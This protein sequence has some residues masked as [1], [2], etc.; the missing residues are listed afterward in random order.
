MVAWIEGLHGLW[1]SLFV[2][3][4]LACMTQQGL[5]LGYAA[6]R[7]W[8][9]RGRKVFE[10]PLKRGQLRQE[11]IGTLMFHFVFAPPL[12]WA[13]ETG[14]IRFATGSWVAEALGFFGPWY[15]FMI[16]YYFMHRSM[17]HKRLFWMH[18]WHHVSLVTTYP[19]PPGASTSPKRPSTIG[20][21]PSG[22]RAATIESRVRNSRQ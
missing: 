10:V 18:K 7:F 6:E 14:T 17:H 1:L 21:I 8:W 13:L 16:F 22:S 9:P 11:A 3:G 19:V 4:A 20:R 15:A 5:A 12:T 2:F